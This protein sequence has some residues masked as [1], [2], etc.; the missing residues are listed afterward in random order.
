M[1]GAA[2]VV[3]ELRP[4]VND[5]LER[6]DSW[7]FDPH[8]WL[9]TNFDC[10]VLYLADRKPLINSLSV[11][12]EYLRNQASESGAVIDYRDWHIPLGRRFRA[13]KLWF[14]IRHYG[15][16]GLREHIAKGVAS[17]RWLA[18]TSRRRRP[19][20]TARADRPVT[21]VLRPPGRRRSNRGTARDRSMPSGRAYLTHTR[22]G[23]RYAIRVAVGGTYTQQADVER[24][25][26]LARSA[27]LAFGAMD[28]LDPGRFDIH[29]A[30]PRGFDAGVRARERRWRRTARAR[31]RLARD[32]AHLV[33]RHRAAGARRLRGHRAGPARLRRLR[34]RARR[35]PRR[36]GSHARDVHALVHDHLGHERAVLVGGD[37]GGPVIQDI[38]LRFPGFARRMVLFNSPLPYD[39]ERMQG[40]RTRPARE[41][42]DYF[43]RQGTDADGLAADLDTEDKRRRYIATFYT[44]RFWAHPGGFLG[45]GDLAPAGR[46][47]GSATI[48]FHTEPFARRREAA[49]QLRRLRERV[50][51]RAP[52]ASRR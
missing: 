33:A 6:V 15:A 27:D 29:R 21:R 24:L 38:A 44:S 39:K 32:E 14:V 41:A 2:A 48:D 20:R 46:F 12:P 43:V 51:R 28:D 5:G 40:M 3:P 42:S 34:R 25:W 13:L 49:G 19:L 16:E 9:L 52:E 1:A 30:S 17:A 31:T 11:L 18:Q 10:D 7:C 35:L 26:S 23:G 50:Q 36:A 47:G 37:L 22:L 45:D 4:L 8:K